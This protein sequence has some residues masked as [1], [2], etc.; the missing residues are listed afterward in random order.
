MA[1]TIFPTS[2]ID[3]QKE[4]I[5]RQQNEREYKNDFPYVL[6]V[7]QYPVYL[8]LPITCAQI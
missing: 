3:G 6:Y 4:R 2:S 1:V 8:I 5:E 7:Y